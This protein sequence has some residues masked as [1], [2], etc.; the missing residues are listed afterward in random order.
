MSKRLEAV[1]DYLSDNIN[2]FRIFE[3]SELI[4]ILSLSMKQ[5]ADKLKGLDVF[6]ECYHEI[7]E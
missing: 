2:E 1:K 4:Y 7:L 5:K 3:I 6:P